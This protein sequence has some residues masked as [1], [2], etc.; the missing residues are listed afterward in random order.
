MKKLI[1]LF[2]VVNTLAANA[3]SKDEKALVERTYLLSHTI[4]GSKD[5]IALQDLFAGKLTYGHSSGKIETRQEAIA[6][7]SHNKSAY[8]DTSVSNIKLIIDDDVAVVRHLF[9]ANENK[10]DGTVSPLNFTMMLVWIKEKG[11]WKL[12]GRQAVKIAET[13]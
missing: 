11:K 1:L 3:Q 8:R 4:F 7:I 13:K 10:P 2:L 6:A 12:M 9:K 5:S